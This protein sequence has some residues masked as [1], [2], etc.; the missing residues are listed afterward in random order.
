MKLFV[1]CAYLFKDLFFDRGR[2]LLTIISLTAV[3][4]SYLATSATTEV[5]MEFGSQPQTGANNLLI[6]SDYALEPMQSNLDDSLLQSAA[7]AVRQGYGPDSVQR[8]SPVIYRTLRFDNKRLQIIAVPLEDM[9]QVHNLEL[10]EGYWPASDEQ[11]VATQE[12]MQLLDWKIGDSLEV[13]DTRLLIVGRVDQAGARMA[14][15]WMNYSSGRELFNAQDNFQIGFL[16]IGDRLDLSTVQAYLEGNAR[17]PGG[18]VV[19]LERQLYERYYHFVADLLKVAFILAVLALG[20]V[21]FGT[22]NTT[23]LTLMER[24]R[25]I[26]ILQTLGFTSRVVR[27]FLL[28]RTLLQTLAA[29][30]LAWVIMAAVVQSSSHSPIA[31]EAKMGVLRLSPET[32]GLGLVLTLFSASLGVWLI[33]RAQNSQNLADQ[34]RE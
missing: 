22:Y 12:A 10:L 25:D 4:V 9:V 27:L 28:G 8:A 1:F 14:A 11:V 33:S 15:I 20:V 18:Y 29:F 26:A 32:L 16:Q 19:Y 6:M 21:C 3:I 24:R 34:L 17:L 30:L 23:S 31:I 13:R 2:S 5:L 7:E